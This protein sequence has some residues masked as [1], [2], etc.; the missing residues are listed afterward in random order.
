MLYV[1]L[2]LVIVTFRS[3]YPSIL[4]HRSGN[5]YAPRIVESLISDGVDMNSHNV[6]KMPTDNLLQQNFC[7]TITET[8]F[9]FAKRKTLRCRCISRV[10]VLQRRMNANKSSHGDFYACPH[11][12]HPNWRSFGVSVPTTSATQT[13][14]T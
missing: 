11:K 7:S 6:L 1:I 4:R 3:L 8:S 14:L 13:P 2:T 5:L 9:D 10:Q 12:Y